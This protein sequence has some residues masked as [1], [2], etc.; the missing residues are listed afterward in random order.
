MARADD[1]I[2]CA[3]IPSNREMNLKKLANAAGAKSAAMLPPAEAERVTGFRVGGI[4]PFG[5][6]RRVRVFIDQAAITHE[7]IMVNGGRRG[8]QIELPPSEL[9]RL[10]GATARPLC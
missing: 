6:K 10:L 7:K 8:L 4:S 2:V 3:L 5:Q 9:V 1:E